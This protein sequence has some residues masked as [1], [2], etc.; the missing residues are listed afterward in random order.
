ML[1]TIAAMKAPKLGPPT[2]FKNQVRSTHT[3]RMVVDTYATAVLEQSDIKLDKIPELTTHQ[4]VARDHAT[5]WDQLVKPQIILTNTSL[6]D[7]GHNFDTFHTPLIKMARDIDR[8]S[9]RENF[10]QGLHLLERKIQ[11]QQEAGQGA[12]DQLQTLRSDVIVDG[13]DLKGD[14]AKAITIY[15]GE[16][17]EIAMLRKANDALQDAMNT[18]IAIMGLG[19]TAAVVG[20]LAISVGVL[21]EIE[22]AGVSTG[23]I[24]VGLVLLAGGGATAG[25]AGLDYWKRASNYA[26]NLE[27]IAKDSLEMAA[28]H[29]M[30]NQINAVVSANRQA[31]GALGHMVD[32]WQKLGTEFNTLIKQLKDDVKPDDGPFLVAELM[33]AKSDW[34]DV[35]KTA[36]VIQNQTDIPVQ[37]T[38][39]KK[40]G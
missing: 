17:G 12:L 34:D 36:E 40:V 8:G 39:L 18:D 1:A 35:I 30:D 19:A 26:A 4:G 14:V 28:I 23:F 6:L 33:A 21:G 24:V 37:H 3:A 7:F 2:N 29:H 38:T 32:S 27:T 25:V 31:V 9:N 22:T 13:R 5:H 10:I 15:G 16:K 11:E 20:V